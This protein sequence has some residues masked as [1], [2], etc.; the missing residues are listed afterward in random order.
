MALARLEI[1]GAVLRRPISRIVH[2]ALAMP[3]RNLSPRI[4]RVAPTARCSQTSLLYDADGNLTFDGSFY[5]THNVLIW[6]PWT[7]Y[8][9]SP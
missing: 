5:H 8:A 7:R 9:D 4:E 3:E 1:G 2:A 6:M